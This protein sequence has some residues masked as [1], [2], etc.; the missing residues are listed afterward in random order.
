MH[1]AQEQ[2]RDFHRACGLARPDIPTFNWKELKGIRLDLIKEEAQEIEDAID[3]HDVLGVIDGVCDLLYVAYGMMVA[4][5]VDVEPYW[6][7][8]Q[9]ANMEK[10]SGPKREDGKQLKPEGWR[11]P[12]HRQI[13]QKLEALSLDQAA[14]TAGRQWRE[15]GGVSHD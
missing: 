3:A 14:G 1:R 11:E 9:R 13:W 6:E 7:E 2:V 5:G 15:E 8:V 4:V 12:N 10:T